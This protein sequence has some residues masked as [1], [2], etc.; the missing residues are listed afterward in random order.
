M[1]VPKQPGAVEDVV[2]VEAIGGR[3]PSVLTLDGQPREIAVGALHLVPGPCAPCAEADEHLARC[4]MRVPTPQCANVPDLV[5]AA[6]RA[7]ASGLPLKAVMEQVHYPDI[8]VALPDGEPGRVTVDL[9]VA[10]NDPWGSEVLAAKAALQGRYG[11]KVQ[12]RVTG[13]DGEIYGRLGVAATPVWAVAGY[14]M[15]GAQ[16]APAIGRIIDRHIK[17]QP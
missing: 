14:R 3:Y 17:G 7:A 2:A 8:W 15:R 11:D 6:V 5:E 1:V 16:S 4:A 10:A 12:V 9:V 13:T